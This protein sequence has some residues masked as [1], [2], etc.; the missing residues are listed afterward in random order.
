MR[1]ARIN[2][3]LPDDLAR[4]ARAAGVSVSNIT[5]A[6]LRRELSARLTAEWL[7]RLDRLP[8]VRVTHEQILAALDIEREEF[9]RRHG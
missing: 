1:I 4:Q 3:Y 6:A 7:S 9:G 2:V 8:A 5:Q